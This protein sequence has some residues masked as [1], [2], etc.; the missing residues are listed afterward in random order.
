MNNNSTLDI[1]KFREQFPEFSDTSKYTDLYMLEKYNM[2]ICYISDLHCSSLT[3]DCTQY[4]LYLMIAHLIKIDDEITANV[5]RGVITSASQGRV[6]TSFETPPSSGPWDYW[7]NT[8]AYG[9]Q[10]KALLDVNSSGGWYVGGSA[11]G[12][13][14]RRLGGYIN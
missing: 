12:S 8:T 7:L 9:Q 13:A 1:V 6:S 3:D 10:L 5:K 4:A 11:V 2:A 14:F